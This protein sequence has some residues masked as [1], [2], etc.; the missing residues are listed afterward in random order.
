MTLGGEGAQ[1]PMEIRVTLR[2]EGS[3]RLMDE[4]CGLNASCKA[5]GTVGI[6]TYDS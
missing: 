2:G 6:C 4:Q 5:I 3:Q 1:R